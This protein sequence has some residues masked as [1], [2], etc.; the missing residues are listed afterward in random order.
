MPALY[1][2]VMA[3]GLGT[4]MKSSVPKFLHLIHNKPMIHYVLD[5]CLR[6]QHTNTIFLIL[7]SQ[8]Y[9]YLSDYSTKISIIIQNNPLGTGHAVQTLFQQGLYFEPQDKFIIINADMP[10]IQSSILESFLQQSEPYSAAL[11]GAKLP[12]PAGY[13]RL[14]FKDSFFLDKI[15]EDKDCTDKQ[16]DYCNMGLYLFTYHVLNSYIFQLTNNNK[17][18]EFYLT[19]IFQFIPSPIFVYMLKPEHAKY[20][21]GVN[22]Q[23]QLLQLSSLLI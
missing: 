21:L 4:R 1:F 23:E 2:V 17:S 19:Q 7:P 6:I 16:N 11:V 8:K 15:E 22:T 18:S 14:L 3:G 20:F 12:N 5:A 9:N 13:G 10:L